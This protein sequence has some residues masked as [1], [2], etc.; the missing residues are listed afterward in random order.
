MQATGQFLLTTQIGLCLLLQSQCIS[1]TPIIPLDPSPTQLLG[2]QNRQPSKPIVLIV[3]ERSIGLNGVPIQRTMTLNVSCCAIDNVRDTLARV[4]AVRVVVNHRAGID[5][6]VGTQRQQS[7]IPVDVAREVHIHLV[8]QQHALPSRAHIGLVARRLG[9]V[10]RPMAHRDNP[11][12]LGTV[13]ALQVIDQPLVLLVR[14]VV[15]DLVIVDGAKGTRV[16]DVGLVDRRVRFVGV[17]ALGDVAEKRP[18]GGVDVI[19]FTVEGDEVCEAVVVAI[20]HVAHAAGFYTR[21]AETVLIGG[22]VTE[23]KHCQ[24][25]CQGLRQGFSSQCKTHRCDGGQL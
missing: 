24:R 20:P 16:G 9:T 23:E 19:C 2:T 5:G 17:R 7:F 18:L 3:Q 25:L 14:S 12:R 15:I 6:P 1:H 8:L 13:D 11:R 10:H 4:G 22:E 21:G